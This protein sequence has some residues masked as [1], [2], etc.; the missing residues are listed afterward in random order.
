MYPDFDDTLVCLHCGY[1][2]YTDTV[3][4]PR[5]DKTIAEY[6]TGRQAPKF[7]DD[8]NYGG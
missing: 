8:P 4:M 7:I 6:H 3:P 2:D 1:E 5:V